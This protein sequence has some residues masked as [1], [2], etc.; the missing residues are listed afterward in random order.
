MILRWRNT[1]WA[2]GLKGLGSPGTKGSC[3]ATR[4][5]LARK[6][7]ARGRA[8]S[9]ERETDRAWE[10]EQSQVHLSQGQLTVK[11]PTLFQAGSGR[12]KVCTLPAYHVTKAASSW[13]SKH[14]TV[15]W[16]QGAQQ[17]SAEPQNSP[18]QFP[19]EF[20]VLGHRPSL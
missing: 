1:A 12:G 16:G 15:Q 17:M 5:G 18:P 7:R 19:K 8:S 9:L 4:I 6:S 20:D 3:K 14:D 2:P 13:M 11:P 10:W